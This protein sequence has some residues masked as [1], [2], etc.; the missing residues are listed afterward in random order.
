VEFVQGG[1]QDSRD[2]GLFTILTRIKDPKNVEKVRDA[3]YAAIDD[4]K[5]KP[6]AADRLAAIKSHLKYN[7]AMGLDNA[8]SIAR[9]ISHY[10]QL[11]GEPESVNRVYDMYDKVSPQ[12]IVMVANKYFS[13]TN[14]TVVLLKQADASRKEGEVQER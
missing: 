3:I 13:P 2:A 11:T 7:F 1:Q 8:D 9:T 4:A 10:V 12:D 14:R 5:A 6:A